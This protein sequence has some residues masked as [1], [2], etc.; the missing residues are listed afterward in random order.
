L[1]IPSDLLP[2]GI[3]YPPEQLAEGSRKP[4]DTFERGLP[5]KQKMSNCFAIPL[6]N[7]KVKQKMQEVFEVFK[8]TKGSATCSLSHSRERVFLRK[9]Q[10]I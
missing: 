3:D 8:S 4:V 6:N 5:H 9:K 1:P 2:E 7:L 10:V